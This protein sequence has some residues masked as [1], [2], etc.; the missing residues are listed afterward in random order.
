MH[1]KDSGKINLDKGNVFK[2]NFVRASSKDVKALGGAVYAENVDELKIEDNMF[3]NN[4]S[5]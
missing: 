3:E 2:S 1:I 4:Y 5:P